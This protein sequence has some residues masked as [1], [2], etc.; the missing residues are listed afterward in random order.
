MVQF[1]P[2]PIKENV[3]VSKVSLK[4]EFFVLTLGLMAI[5]VVSYLALGLA[6]DILIDRM[7]AKVEQ[8]AAKLF[9]FKGFET[10]EKYQ[11]ANKEIQ[12]LLDE[13]A[14][15]WPE[16]SRAFTVHIVESEDANAFALPGGRIVLMSGLLKEVESQ[17]ELAMILGHELGHYAH[18][19]HLR[20]LGRGVVFMVA[21]S[22]LFGT[23]S[24]VADLIGTT[25]STIDLKFSRTQE[26]RADQFALGLLN[27]KYGH[28]AGA[29]DFFERLEKKKDLPRFLNFLLTHPLSAQRIDMI[30]NNIVS[31]HYTIEPKIPVN[32]D[33]KELFSLKKEGM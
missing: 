24:G 15:Y 31:L 1:T 19:D 11:E 5:L 4:S 23:D 3:N 30:N 22:V 18:R 26:M 2:R 16:S 12:A 9:Q 14:A 29:T 33:F 7:P 13:V 25:L 6:M 28:V 17:N 20:A 27:K 32:P 10:P 8:A 21:A